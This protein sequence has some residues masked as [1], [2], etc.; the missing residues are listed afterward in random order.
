MREPARPGARIVGVLISV[1]SIV[2]IINLV[3]LGH[4]NKSAAYGLA[5]CAGLAGIPFGLAAAIVGAP[6]RAVSWP[7]WCTAAAAYLVVAGVA[8]YFLTWRYERRRPHR[9]PAA[10]GRATDRGWTYCMRGVSRVTD[11][12]GAS[13]YSCWPMAWADKWTGTSDEGAFNG[14]RTRG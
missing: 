7:K 12:T 4:G 3:M 10:Q 14:R 6:S 13:V 1:V 9:T 11:V 5:Y 2:W 8:L